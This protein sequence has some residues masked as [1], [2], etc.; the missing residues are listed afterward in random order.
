MRKTILTFTLAAL[1]LAGCASQENGGNT[2][3]ADTEN[4]GTTPVSKIWEGYEELQGKQYGGVFTMPDV[5]TP[6]SA[7]EYYTFLW[8]FDP[9][10]EADE[11]F[12]REFYKSFFGESYKDEYVTV[13]D[14]NVLY[15]AP[16]GAFGAV[17]STVIV[18]ASRDG[19]FPA[20][21]ELLGEYDPVK[22][23]A[24]SMEL[25]EGSCTVSEAVAAASE[26]M[27]KTF[28]AYYPEYE[29]VPVRV[30]YI[31]SKMAHPYDPPGELVATAQV[32]F[33]VSYKG[34]FL[35]DAS[36]LFETENKGY[37]MVSTSIIPSCIDLDI[38]KKGSVSVINSMGKLPA[39]VSEQVDELMSLDQAVELMESELAPQSGYKF[40]RV[41]LRYCCKYSMP[42]LIPTEETMGKDIILDF[43]EETAKMFEE[44]G[45]VVRRFDPTWCFYFGVEGSGTSV[46]VNARTGEITIDQEVIY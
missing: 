34:L 32:H 6:N 19:S 1:M 22:D 11:P 38:N 23:G 33:M 25:E 44:F 3:Q 15:N 13:K 7:E 40:S 30:K 31:A 17:A 16:D 24:V 28:A 9:Y 35:E 12:A 10:P 45:E 39:P 21:G 41:E 27:D 8:D 36:L 5:I 2:R 26:L 29:Y 20:D 37:Y 42:Q 14:F 46:R 4:I 18:N 43:P